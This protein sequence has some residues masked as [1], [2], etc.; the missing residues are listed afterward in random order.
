MGYARLRRRRGIYLNYRKLP[1]LRRN[2]R[3]S[4]TLAVDV[5]KCLQKSPPFKLTATGKLLN[6]FLA[7]AVVN[8]LSLGR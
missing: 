5:G 3:I 6:E 1:T 7:P 4:V 2:S 8:P